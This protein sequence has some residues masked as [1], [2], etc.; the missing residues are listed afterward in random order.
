MRLFGGRYA[1]HE[2]PGGAGLVIHSARII[3]YVGKIRI[4]LSGLVC[5]D[6]DLFLILFEHQ[7]GTVMYV[8]PCRR[9]RH[10]PGEV[11]IIQG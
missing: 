9:D 3:L 8:S 6:N 5:S 10:R 4:A 2:S 11:N 1:L 7:A